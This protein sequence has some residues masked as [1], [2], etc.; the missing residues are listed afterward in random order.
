MSNLPLSHK[1]D[2]SLTDY[3]YSGSPARFEEEFNIQILNTP[4]QQS[5]Q[6]IHNWLSFLP[7]VKQSI[8]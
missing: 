6:S 3:E 5:I 8:L 4:L 1:A 2:S 7:D